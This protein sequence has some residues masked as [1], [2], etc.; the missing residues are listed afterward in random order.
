M[1]ADEAGVKSIHEVDGKFSEA[2]LR[3]VPASARGNPAS[4]RFPMKA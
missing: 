1:G 4:V 2:T 3:T